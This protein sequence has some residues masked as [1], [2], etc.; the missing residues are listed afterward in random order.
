MMKNMT[1]AIDW[2]EAFDNMQGRDPQTLMADWQSRSDDFKT[3][4]AEIGQMELDISYGDHSRQ[5]Y[6]L[7][8]PDGKSKGTIVFIHGG[9]W[10][11]TGRKYWSFLAEG[12]LAHGWAVAI[13]SYPFA[14]EVR[15]SSITTSIVNAVHHIASHHQGIIRL[16]GHSAGG[17]LVSRLLCKGVLSDEILSHIEQAISVS[18]VHDLR[19]L[20]L[21]KMNDILNLDLPEAEAESSVLLTPHDIPLTCWVGGDERA[22]FLRQNRLLQEYWSGQLDAAHQIKAVYD[23]GHNHF[24]VIEQLADFNSPLVQMI[25]A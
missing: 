2:D 22:E 9:Y 21:T 4:W 25:T 7:F 3:R 14:P 12:M 13:P 16:I 24:T 5:C 18:G 1:W 15:I 19:P 10:M 20:L 6:D 17:H 23:P 8:M 11:R